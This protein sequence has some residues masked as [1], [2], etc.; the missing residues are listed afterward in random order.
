MKHIKTIMALMFFLAMT[1]CEKEI[2][3]S[4]KNATNNITINALVVP[5]T[6]VTAYITEAANLDYFGT[7]LTRSDYYDYD[8]IDMSKDFELSYDEVFKESC[9]TEAEVYLTINGS[10]TYLMK[11]NKNTYSYNSEYTPR[12]GD[13]I[14]IDVSSKSNSK[15]QIQLDNASATAKLPSMTP[16]IEVMETEIKYKAK[17]YY[18]V[19]DDIDDETGEIM[20]I[21]DY[22]GA[23]TVMILKL[24]ISDPGNEMN[25]Y[26]LKIRS[27]G[28]SRLY[29][30][31]MSAAVMKYSAVDMFDSDD[32]L[33]YESDLGKGYGYIPANFSN[34]FDDELINGKEYEFTVETRMRRLSEI[35]P[36]VVVEL[37][38]LSPE[39]YYY[40][41]DI[42]IFR[43]SDFDLYDNPIQINS[44]VTGGWGMFGAM[45]YDTHKVYFDNKN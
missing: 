35:T 26:R 25:Y 29:A 13:E 21:S 24:K 34:V 15:E 23:D 20:H 8:K 40:L 41:K 19:G 42:E 3:I 18:E 17:P 31:S 36:Y 22:W 1:A 7:L 5:D 44:N 16:K 11:Y 9:L 12:L 6:V 14:R 45:T 37:Q 32:I 43:I 38:H 27:V 2:D 33:F 4:F 10:D 30:G 28:A 39:L